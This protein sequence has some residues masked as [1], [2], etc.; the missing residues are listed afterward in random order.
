MVNSG[1]K[2]EDYNITWEKLENESYTRLKALYNGG[3]LKPTDL[4]FEND[5][6][7]DIYLAEYNL[8]L[9]TEEDIRN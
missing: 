3:N 5:A 7:D 2:N 6:E 9:E 8:K 1:K 4:F